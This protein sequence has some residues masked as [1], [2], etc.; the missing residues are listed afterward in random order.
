LHVS[1]HVP[2]V[3]V[4]VPSAVGQAFAHP[5]HDSMLVV[6]STQPPLHALVGKGQVVAVTQAPFSQSCPAPHDVLHEPHVAEVLKS[7]SHPFAGLPSQSAR[8]AGHDPTAHAPDLHV[9][10]T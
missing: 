3:H 9:I 4:A 8:P 1:P 5:P 10:V 7:A 2:F 6:S